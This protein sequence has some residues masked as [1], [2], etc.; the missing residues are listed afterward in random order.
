VRACSHPDY[1]VA[2]PEGH[3]FPMRKFS[4]LREIVLREGICRR[5]EIVEPEEAS[6]ELLATV[7]ARAY[8]EALASGTLAREA[9]RRL[10]LPW[11][12]PLWRRSRLAVTGTLLAGEMALADGI[13]ANL[14]GGT[15]H[16]LPDAGEGFCVLN[17]VAIA[18][19]E[20]RRRGRAKRFLVVDLDVHQGNGT[21]ACLA[22]DDA[23]F[24]FSMHGEKN[25]PLR[26]MP[27]DLDVG[28]PDHTGDLAYLDALAKH[29]PQAIE[30]SRPDLCLYLAGVDVVIGDRYGRL[31][32]TRE[33]LRERD[34][35]VVESLRERGIPTTL[36]L[37]G[38]YAKTPELTA[39]LHATAHRVATG[40]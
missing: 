34:R 13:A 19:G 33:G 16:A 30:R 26:K 40:R 8:L 31:A 35:M 28:L 23:A 7:H 32:L 38:G 12:P 4:L 20:L 36:L 3:P 24:T 1:E 10:G 14:A 18:V 15:H 25:F 2:L 22:A 17:D 27:S 29:L 6:L 37:S 11:S 21:A 39:D 5:D 9:E